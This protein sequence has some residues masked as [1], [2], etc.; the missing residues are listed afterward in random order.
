[1]PAQ[2]KTDWKLKFIEQ[3]MIKTLF[4][5][6]SENKKLNPLIIQIVYTV[7]CKISWSNQTFF[8]YEFYSFDKLAF[9][10]FYF[11]FKY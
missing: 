9:F 2:K 1:M 4:S 8:T 3:M 5:I 10:Y 11:W 6:S 7:R